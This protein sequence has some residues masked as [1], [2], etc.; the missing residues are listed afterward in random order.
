VKPAAG[1]AVL[2][3][4]GALHRVEPVTSGER[5]ACVGWIQSLV[6]QAEHRELLFDLARV[7]GALGEGEARLLLDKSI[8]NLLRLWAAP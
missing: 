2:Y 8:A 6:P 4:T 3:S 1:T 7:R 5:L